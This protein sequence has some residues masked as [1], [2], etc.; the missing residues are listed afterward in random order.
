MLCNLPAPSELITYQGAMV[1]IRWQHPERGTIP[2]MN[3]IPWAEY[4][5][6]ILPIGKWV[7]DNVCAQLQTWQQDHFT[8]DIVLAVSVSPGNFIKLDLWSKY[9]PP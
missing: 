4:I 9:W 7:L 6:L 3:F 8:S 2:P 5:G 1:S